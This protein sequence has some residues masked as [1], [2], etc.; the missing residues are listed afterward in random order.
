MRH[1]GLEVLI[2]VSYT[3]NLEEPWENPGRS[4]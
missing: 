1:V 2:N 3:F 4:L